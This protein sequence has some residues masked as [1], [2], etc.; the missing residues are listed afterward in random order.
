MIGRAAVE[1]MHLDG[2]LDE[3][4]WTA[5]DSITDFRQ[6]EPR[7]GVPAT[8]CT[9]VRALYTPD[10]L[11]VGV[12]AWDTAPQAIRATQLRRDADLTVDDYVTLL[13]DSFRDRRGA[14]LFRT[15]PNGA[16]WDAQLVGFEDP[17]ANWNGIWD[18]ATTRDAAGWTAEFRIPFRT[19]RYHA[20]ETGFG[21][22]IER[23]VRRKNEETLWRS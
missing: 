22:N 1:T 9:V 16:R 19:L 2:R 20:G 6:R 13:I 17:D 11:Y 10:A 8:E 7:E 4:A 14:F 5:T 3:P 21:F 18:V 23:F 15:N 12:R